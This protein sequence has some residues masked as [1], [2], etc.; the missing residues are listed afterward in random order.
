MVPGLTQAPL[1]LPPPHLLNPISSQALQIPSLCISHTTLFFPSPLLSRQF[2][3]SLPS[4]PRQQPNWSFHFPVPLCPHTSR[5]IPQAL[6]CSSDQGLPKNAGHRNNDVQSL[7]LTLKTAYQELQPTF[8]TPCPHASFLVFLLLGKVVHCLMKSSY[9]SPTVILFT[10][11]LVMERP[12]SL[13]TSHVCLQMI[14]RTCWELVKISHYLP[15][16]PVPVPHQE[17]HF[18]L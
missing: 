2:M 1:I 8:Q 12:P 15:P 4:A 10:H 17:C 3:N 7:I 5:R 11:N 18:L 14:L 13:S 6:N 9:F 16:F